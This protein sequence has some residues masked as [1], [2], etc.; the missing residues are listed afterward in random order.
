M[1]RKYIFDP[2][3]ILHQEPVQVRQDMTYEERPIEILDRKEKELRNKKIPLVKV[4]WKN[5]SIEEAT[6]EREE[7][8]K[9]KYPDLF[10]T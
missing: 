2:S 3:H 7:E 1:L 9:A 4:L 8:I 5:H 10:G 6:R